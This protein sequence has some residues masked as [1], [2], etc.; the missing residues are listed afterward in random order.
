MEPLAPLELSIGWG[1]LH[2]FYRVD[3]GR[4]DG[5]GQALGRVLEA[6]RELEADD[7]QALCF[8]VLGHKADIGVMALGPDLTRLHA[9]QQQ[10]ATTTPLTLV[11]SFVSFTEQSEYTT[12]E[13]DERA[14]LVSEQGL[15][16]SDLDAA[17][18]TWRDRMAHYREQRLHPRLP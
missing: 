18:D 10:L 11:D 8:S 4:V 3:R 7:H 9:F 1:V 14:R 13:D 12:S 16:G 6:V 15:A 5:E 17:L 2:L